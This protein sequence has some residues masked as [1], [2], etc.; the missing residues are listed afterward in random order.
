L[1]LD[2]ERIS[3]LIFDVQMQDSEQD[4]KRIVDILKRAAANSKAAGIP[5]IPI[6]PPTANL[7]TLSKCNSV[8]E[9]ASPSGSQ[10]PE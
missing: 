10:A 6:L 7:F 8:Y 3:D 5:T 4:R 9:L 2:R 1:K